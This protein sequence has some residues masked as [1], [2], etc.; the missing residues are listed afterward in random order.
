MGPRPAKRPARAQKSLSARPLLVHA[1]APTVARPAQVAQ[2]CTGPARAASHTRADTAT[3]TRGGGGHADAAACSKGCAVSP[4]P[5]SQ[6]SGSASSPP[7]ART[8]T[9]ACK[10]ERGRPTRSNPAA[11]MH[12]ESREETV[13]GDAPGTWGPGTR[14]PLFSPPVP[15]RLHDVGRMRPSSSDSLSGWS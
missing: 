8:A 7:D 2:A 4:K 3:G 11:V 10:P 14:R 5:S 13:A 12:A 15:R 9:G 1:S 6:R